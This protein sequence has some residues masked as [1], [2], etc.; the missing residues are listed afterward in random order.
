MQ[1]M[2][3]RQNQMLMHQTFLRMRERAQHSSASTGV[4]VSVY[5]C[6]RTASG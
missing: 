3:A 5:L 4:L 6:V 1:W 2:P